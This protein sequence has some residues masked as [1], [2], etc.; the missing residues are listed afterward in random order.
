MARLELVETGWTLIP[1]GNHT[2]TVD[3]AEYDEEWDKVVIEY[4]TDTGHTH[5]D[6]YTLVVNGK[7]NE[8]AQKA[9]SYMAKAI[10]G[11]FTLESVDTD[12]LV[13][14]MFTADVSHVESG[15]NEETGKPYTNA[16]LNNVTPVDALKQAQDDFDF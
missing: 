1:E 3:S 5:T 10:L 16:R 9:M 14:K 6:R 15:M 4:S 12:E 13:G 7:I 8:G 11:D 2:F